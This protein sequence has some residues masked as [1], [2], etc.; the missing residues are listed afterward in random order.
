M[1]P[2]IRPFSTIGMAPPP[3]ITRPLLDTIRLWNQ[4]CPA[5]LLSSSV[6]CWKLA[7][8][9]ALFMAMSTV[10][11]R[12]VS[13]RPRATS[14]PLSSTTTAVIARSMLSASAWAAW[15][16]CIAFST[17]MLMLVCSETFRLER[18]LP[19]RRGC[20]YTGGGLEARAPRLQ[21][22][23]RPDDRAPHVRDGAA[24]EPKPFLGLLEVAADDVREVIDVDDGV[25]VERVEI[26]EGDQ[27]AGHVPF[28]VARP[29][30]LLFNVRL[31]LV[32][33]P[34]QLDV[35]LRVL[36]TNG[37]VWEEPERL[38]A[39]DR[40]TDLFVDVRGDELLAPVAM[41]ATDE[42]DDADIV[43]EAGHDDL[44]VV[45]VSQGE[46][47]ALEQMGLRGREP[48]LEE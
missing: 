30:V 32:I 40:P 4:A 1:A 11:G 37:V 15:M 34:H 23:G 33:R 35:H 25:R 44:L 24:V 27:A 12:A 17:E 22:L 6:G 38:V 3:A 39:A 14:R 7:A 47:G 28:V 18:G 16:S 26:V 46:G 43:Q 36:V 31:D 10:I 21:V 13:M 48:V 2:S 41:I 9:Y 45:A 8:V 5:A 19:G 20:V 42:P 29:L